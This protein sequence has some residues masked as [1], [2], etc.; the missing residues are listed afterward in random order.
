[1]KPVPAKTLHA[2]VQPIITAGNKKK[3][4]DDRRF[5]VSSPGRMTEYTFSSASG[6]ASRTAIILII[7]I[8]N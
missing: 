7:Y 2:N 8:H 4:I 6:N 1:M 5:R 3:R